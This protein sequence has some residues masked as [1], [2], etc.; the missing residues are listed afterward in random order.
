[1]TYF[2]EKKVK[3][4]GNWKLYFKT[5]IMFAL[6]ITPLILMLTLSL[7]AWTQATIYGHYG[8]RYGWCWYECN[9]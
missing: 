8:R 3:K 4:T 6:F 7:P 5:I 9:A 1:M 2:K